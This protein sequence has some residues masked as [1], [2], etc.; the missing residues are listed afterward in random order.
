MK[1]KRA[2]KKVKAK[3]CNC[4]AR[5]KANIDHQELY[6]KNF[7]FPENQ[8]QNFDIVI[9]L[10]W[11]GINN[12]YQTMFIDFCRRFHFH[13][14]ASICIIPALGC[15]PKNLSMNDVVSPYI[16]CKY[17]NIKKR[18]EYLNP[19]TIITVGRA[20]YS[21]IEN[22]DLRYNHFYNPLGINPDHFLDKDSYFY[23]SEYECNVFP[24]PPLYMTNGLICYESKFTKKQF[25]RC[26]WEF[27]KIKRRK[28]KIEFE[29]VDDPN[30]LLNQILNNKDILEI[31]IDTETSGF[32]YFKEKLYNISLSWDGKKGYFLPFDKINKNLLIQLFDTNI[33]WIFHNSQFDLKFLRV[34]GIYNVKSDF[35]TML[36]SHILNENNPNSLKALSWLYTE[37][38]GYEDKVKKYLRQYNVSDFTKLPKKL[39]VEYACYDAIITF[40]LYKYFKNR[41][42]RED[43]FVKDNFYN[44]VMPAIGMITDV[45][46]AGIQ[47]DM[48]YLKEYS[49]NLKKKR[50][51]ME[52]DIYTIVGKKFN[53]KSGKDMDQV[54][55]NMKGFKILQDERGN[56][57]VTKKNE[58]KRDK[59]TL[60]L[61]AENGFKFAEK[62][63]EYNH[64]TKELEQFGMG[65]KKKGV[66]KK[67]GLINSIYKNRLHGGF[68]L[69][70]TKTGRMAGGGG[71]DSTVNLQNQPKT[72]EFKKLFLPSEGFIFGDLDYDSMEVNIGSQI[73]GPGELEKLILAGKDMHTWTASKI[74]E[75]LDRKTLGL[76]MQ[77][78]FDTD[79]K[80]QKHYGKNFNVIDYMQKADLSYSNIFTC[81]KIDES[82][83]PIIAEFREGAKILNFQC[84]YGA[85]EYALSISLKTDIY[86]ARDLLKTFYEAYPEFKKY[87]DESLRHAQ[88]Y[89]WVST[90]LGRK[91][92]LPQLTYLNIEID[93]SIPNLSSLYSLEETKIK[94]KNIINNL[95]NASY[96]SRIQGTSGQTT[97][98]TMIEIWKEFKKRNYKSRLIGNVHDAILLE[99]YLPE[100]EE[101][102]KIVKDCV[103]KIYYTNVGENKVTLSGTMKLGEI[104]DFCYSETYWQN[105]P[106]EWEKCLES[107]KLRNKKLS[108]VKI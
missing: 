35:D 8:K 72:K 14:K 56:D 9:L 29:Y 81:S 32:N 95:K 3:S 60:A 44:F 102:K 88:K 80:L 66:K 91:R 99:I 85:T 28:I 15:T 106:E 107:I 103:K 64:I 25:E 7:K 104:W 6:K 83:E 77:G 94:M 75:K 108:E 79:E 97:V 59:E 31:A 68:K 24:I 12:R 47:V 67:V 11:W 10:E 89:G 27:K 96:N 63:I 2:F 21:I 48:N 49:N 45:E 101:V 71:L 22:S 53:I 26:I 36:A 98:I 20:I 82:I 105:N 78:I 23:S 51:K 57:L 93:D 84:L 86:T 65:K 46:L 58:V 42:E 61:Y 39:L 52:K 90:L 5:K 76:Y 50:D 73:S 100:L 17:Y 37:Y 18:I 16:N 41:L 69:H 38:G 92:R 4:S 70:G 33:K 74:A 1:I 34:N 30:Y 54:L 43:K 40:Q 87:M 13:Y 19:K 62:L 55:K